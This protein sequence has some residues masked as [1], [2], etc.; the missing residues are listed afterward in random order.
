MTILSAHFTRQKKTMNFNEQFVELRPSPTNASKSVISY[1]V[2]NTTQISF[3]SPLALLLIAIFRTH[4][5]KPL[6]KSP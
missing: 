3:I 4:A 2:E 6:I 5:C 1:H